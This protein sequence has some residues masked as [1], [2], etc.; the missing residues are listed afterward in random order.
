[1]IPNYIDEEALQMIDTLLLEADNNLT[2][3]LNKIMPFRDGNPHW[4]FLMAIGIFVHNYCHSRLTLDFPI[5]EA[6]GMGF[7]VLMQNPEVQAQISKIMAMAAHNTMM[8]GS[9]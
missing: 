9:Q 2:I 8:G 7:N 3:L 1:M 6:A 5:E 4:T